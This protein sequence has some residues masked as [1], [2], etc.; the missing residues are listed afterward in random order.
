MLKSVDFWETPA[1]AGQRIG[2]FFYN[3]H[4][5]DSIN[6]K[7]FKEAKTSEVYNRQQLP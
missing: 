5:L 6:Y 4:R 2:R 1:P 3:I 7:I